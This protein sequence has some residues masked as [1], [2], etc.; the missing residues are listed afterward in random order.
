MALDIA[1]TT[2]TP[3][4]ARVVQDRTAQRALEVTAPAIEQGVIGYAEGQLQ[5]EITNVESQAMQ[6]QAYINDLRAQQ[7][8]L[9]P[10]KDEE[11]AA[12][13]ELNTEI[14]RVMKGQKQGVMSS[15]QGEARI[16][17]TVRRLSR[18]FPLA[19]GTLRSLVSGGTLS[20][21][22]SAALNALSA[23][24][25][26]YQAVR[27]KKDTDMIAAGL[28]PANPQAV[29]NWDIL[30]LQTQDIVLATEIAKREAALLA[31][32]NSKDEALNKRKAAAFAENELDSFNTST[33]K[34]MAG[35]ERD[36][37]GGIKN[38]AIALST[39]DTM[40]AA[41][42]ASLL[43]LEGLQ[44]VDFSAEFARLA[45]QGASLKS[46]I[47]NG[48][49]TKVNQAIL[50]DLSTTTTLNL[51]ERA[52]VFVYLADKFPNVLEGR[53]Q[54]Q[55][56]GET[57]LTLFDE[58]FHFN[59][60]QAAVATTQGLQSGA[61]TN[62]D[63]D[64]ITTIL[65]EIPT[66]EMAPALRDAA[67]S[68]LPQGRMNRFLKGA[69]KEYARENPSEYNFRFNTETAA[70]AADPT[71]QAALASGNSFTYDE[72][73]KTLV[74]LDA[75]GTYVQ[76]YTMPQGRSK[77]QQAAA[78]GRA[79]QFMQ[80]LPG[81]NREP[82]TTDGRARRPVLAGEKITDNLLRKLTENLENLRVNGDIIKDYSIN[83]YFDTIRSNTGR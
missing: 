59:D 74:V 24:E 63:A 41:A 71:L 2:Y 21:T 57:M 13:V 35:L 33:L 70:I 42:Q 32:N 31:A 8:S 39:I 58:A 62:E 54:A 20:A 16:S 17:S 3:V 72:N 10:A 19:A 80:S 38:S 28:D 53:M 69:G 49:V 61:V 66:L 22:S 76:H 67:F 60:I 52:P 64:K 26:R 5:R 45:S 15:A 34:F 9:D 75:N 55:L 25:E 68:S 56:A 82:E 40:V 14:D 29:K 18:Q 43:S 78:R 7:A 11:L 51:Q 36:E 50:S 30:T 79:Q 1:E 12:A 27:A 46:I 44:G 48:N 81:V 83:T 23:E 37:R 6:T 73:S 77:V 4:N 47:E 65:N